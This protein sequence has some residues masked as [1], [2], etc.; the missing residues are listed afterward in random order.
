MG[1]IETRVLSRPRPKNPVLVCGVPGSGYVGKL[2]A[3]Y[4]VN[5]FK[6][7]KVVEYYSPTFPPHVNITDDGQALRPP[8]LRETLFVMVSSQGRSR[9]LCSGFFELPA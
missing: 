1:E 7:Q 6:G 3:D 9:E 5:T 4:L 8:L 2:G